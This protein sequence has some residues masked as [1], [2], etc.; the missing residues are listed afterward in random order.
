MNYCL[1]ASEYVLSNF[2]L[3]LHLV[4]T[5]FSRKILIHKTTNDYIL[6]LP[7]TLQTKSCAVITSQKV[8]SKNIT[9]QIHLSQL[10]LTLITI[11]QSVITSGTSNVN[12][13]SNRVY[14]ITGKNANS[15]R[16]VFFHLCL[17][18]RNFNLCYFFV[19]YQY[20]ISNSNAVRQ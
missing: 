10:A 2:I 14:M 15:K 6:I 20:W 7:V 16:A 19:Q 18:K 8:E 17:M 13:S 3:L 9:V 4:I 11:N 5:I 1:S 12:I